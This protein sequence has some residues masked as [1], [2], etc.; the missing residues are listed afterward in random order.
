MISDL[1]KNDIEIEYYTTINLS[2]LHKKLDGWII[3]NFQMLIK[4]LRMNFTMTQNQQKHEKCHAAALLLH[5]YLHVTILNKITSTL[6]SGSVNY[7]DALNTYNSF[8]T[9]DPCQIFPGLQ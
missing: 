7:S 5:V 1:Q 9:N 8:Y 4:S 2:N 6:S 3:R